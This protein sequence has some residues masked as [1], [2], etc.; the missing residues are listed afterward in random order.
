M[1]GKMNLL[2]NFLIFKE[3]KKKNEFKLEEP[4]DES[5]KILPQNPLYISKK[6]HSGNKSE[7]QK[8]EK[9]SANLET[10]CNYIKQSF[11]FPT[12][13]DVLIR[14]FDIFFGG[15]S[16][17]AFIVFID[18]L[19]N[20]AIVN[21]Y[22]LQPLMIFSNS[23]DTE[24]KNI[25]DF[26]ERNL[27]VADQL[28]KFDTFSD[29][30]Y[31]INF[32]CCLLFIDTVSTAF[33]L[34]VKTWEHRS[35]EK[36]EIEMSLFGPQES[37]NETIRVN[38]SLIRKTLRNENL[39][40]ESLTI[41]KRSKTPCCI[42]YLKDLA[43]PSLVD[44]VR[45]R[46]SNLN[47]DY[48]DGSG[49]IE[50]LIE[51]DNFLFSPE[52]LAT[53]RPDKVSSMLCE[54]MVAIIIDGD[55]FVLVVPVTIFDLLHSPDDSYLKFPFGNFIR[56]IRYTGILIA[57]LL[58]GLYIA[59]TTF[60]QEM[61]PTNLL[62]AISA[63]REI[64]PFP[65]VV[66]I[67]VME[68]AFE[69]IREAGARMP[70]NVG[71]TLGIIGALILGQAAVAANIVSPIL[72]IIVSVT[73]IGSLVISNMSLSYAFRLVKFGFIFLGAIS[74]LL[75]ITFGLFIFFA[76]L[77]NATSFGVPYFAPIAPKTASSNSDSWFRLPIW[78]NEKRPD[79]LNPQDDI[80]QPEISRGWIKQ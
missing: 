51:K 23:T 20:H 21:Q 55:P 34:D 36:P 40:F 59:I 32:G 72:I 73:G 24:N 50:Q 53:E 4:K 25:A 65:V 39:I 7:Q 63:S 15:K 49:I 61:I 5:N 37:F 43:N 38:T 27:L 10:N 48:A 22:I 47:I 3:P 57:F 77:V 79:Y 13:N 56:F 62:L 71:P 12:S 1:G 66:E 16:H 41:G 67:L 35:V 42:S 31:Q 6:K 33:S 19:V 68:F 58:P 75:G 11:S 60:H 44:E 9:V 17:K 28:K 14:E 18:G 78:M 69:L 74:G 30:F 2:K 54:G 8:L 45:R 46:L 52:I 29:I 76:L 70:S 64:V 26:V 80:R